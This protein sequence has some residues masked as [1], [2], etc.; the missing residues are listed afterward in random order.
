MSAASGVKGTGT[1]APKRPAKI[2]GGAAFRLPLLLAVALAL[3]G[4]AGGQALSLLQRAM[5]V[6][7]ADDTAQL[8]CTAYQSQNYDILLNVIDPTPVPPTQTGPFDATARTSLANTLKSL[9]AGSGEVTSCA[10]QEPLPQS[11]S[12]L[13][14]IL[15]MRRTRVTVDITMPI[16]LL[17]QP[18]GS[19]KVS[20]GSDF[21]GIPGHPAG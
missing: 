14:Y 11:G 16:T 17:R 12:A 7:T 4:V 1:A 8:V 19:W 13:R 9:D 10:Y 3:M 20:R 2:S 15:T 21:T 6:P 5:R 18:D